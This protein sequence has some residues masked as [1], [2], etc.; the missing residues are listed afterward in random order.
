VFEN[1]KGLFNP[2]SVIAVNPKKFPHVKYDLAMK[3]V[4]FITGPE[5]QKIIANYKVEGDPIFLSTSK[6]R[7]TWDHWRNPS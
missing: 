5:G 6:R 2:Y 3:F 7:C 1:E 4:D